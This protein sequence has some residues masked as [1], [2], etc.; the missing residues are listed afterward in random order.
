LGIEKQENWYCVCPEN[1]IKL[2]ATGLISNYF[3]DSF[4]NAIQNIYSEFRWNVRR[5]SCSP[6]NFWKVWTNQREA[7][8]KITNR[9]GIEKQSDWYSISGMQLKRVGVQGLLGPFNDSFISA[10]QHAYPEYEWHRFF[11]RYVP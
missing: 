7:F 1:V 9:L 10:I 5:F 4:V 3:Q 6:R 2:G 8:D 11:F